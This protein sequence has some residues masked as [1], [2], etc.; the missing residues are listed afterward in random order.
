M[1]LTGKTAVT[2]A[3]VSSTQSL[4]DVIVI[5]YGTVKRKDA[6]GSMTTVSSKE[7]NQGVITSPDQLLSNKVSGLEVTSN[8]GQPGAATTVRIRGNSSVRGVGNPLYVVDGVILDGRDASPNV[9][10]GTGGFGV[11]PESNPLLFINPYDIADI[12]ILKDASSTAI[13]GSRGANGVI[14]ITTKKG[15]SGAVRLEA[16][17]SVGW[18]TGYM[19]KYDI[20]DYGQFTTALTKYNSDSV[21][22]AL[23]KGAHVDPLN[24]ITQS[25]AIQNYDIAVSGGNDNGKFRASFLGSSTPGFIQNNKLDKYIGTFSGSYKFLDK[26][27]SIDFS[28]IDGHTTNH[29]VLASNTAGSA[30]NLISAALQWNPTAAYYNPDGS[31]VNLGNGTPN[32][33]MALKAY[34]DIAE[35]N[36][37]FGKYFRQ[38]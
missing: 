13:Y 9:T 8:S 21:A 18:N 4:N 33:L 14:V 35:V 17:A 20:L 2:A 16:N 22:K 38:L 7:F 12:T 25:T 30:G 15:S 11:L 10:L 3:L 34:N 1:T 23:N 24:D 27:L 29:I 32:P 5:G 31:F 6:T 19:K 28:V 37:V 26:R 36:T